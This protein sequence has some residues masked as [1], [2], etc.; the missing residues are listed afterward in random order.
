MRVEFRRGFR[1]FLSGGRILGRSDKLVNKEN[2]SNLK[3]ISTI[4]RR[5]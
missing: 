4:L 1:V 3:G 2:N 5:R